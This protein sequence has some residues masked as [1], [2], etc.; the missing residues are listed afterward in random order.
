[1]SS[2]ILSCASC[3]KTNPSQTAFCNACGESLQGVGGG[4]PAIAAQL[5]HHLLNERYR[6]LEQIGQGGFGS[7]YKAAD[8]RIAD[9][10]VAV[11]EMEMRG[12]TVQEIAEATNSFQQE[13]I[14]L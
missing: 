1:M 4:G 8:T 5:P 11:K 9:R 6:I 7:V 14:M 12:L 2:T 13:A 10:L 3:G